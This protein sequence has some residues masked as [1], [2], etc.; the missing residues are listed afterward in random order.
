MEEEKNVL[1]VSDHPNKPL[2][3]VYVRLRSVYA[4]ISLLGR[5]VQI[6]DHDIKAHVTRELVN[7]N[8]SRYDWTEKMHNI[9]TIYQSNQQPREDV[10][11]KAVVHNHWFYIKAS[12]LASKDTFDAVI[13][14]YTLTSA[15]A[16]SNNSMPVLTIPVTSSGR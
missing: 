9:L 7:I 5:A 2:N 6:P 12:D 16:A 11:V 4:I 8:G 1:R 15:V 13:R 3:I 10:L 14:L